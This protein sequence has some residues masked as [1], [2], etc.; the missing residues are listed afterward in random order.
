[1]PFDFLNA[2]PHFLI[3]RINQALEPSTLQKSEGL[4][5]AYGGALSLTQPFKE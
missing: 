4:S 2:R 3:S 1:M 5:Y